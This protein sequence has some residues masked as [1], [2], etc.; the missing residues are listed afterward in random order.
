MVHPALSTL[1]HLFERSALDVYFVEAAER[2]NGH[3][4]AMWIQRDMSVNADLFLFSQ[5]TDCP[6]EVLA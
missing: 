3:S 6:F 4:S 1:S 5:V 2:V